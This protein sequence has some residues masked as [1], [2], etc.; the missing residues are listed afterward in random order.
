MEI[1]LNDRKSVGSRSKPRRFADWLRRTMG[2]L[3][4]NTLPPERWERGLSP[5]EQQAAQRRIAELIDNI[6]EQPR[7][8]PPQKPN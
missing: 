6:A 8:K 2:K 3:K 7:R 5:V 1:V 4:R